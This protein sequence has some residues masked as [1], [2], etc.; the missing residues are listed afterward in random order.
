MLKKLM[1]SINECNIDKSLI[2]NIDII[3]VDNDAARSARK[4]VEELT[5]NFGDF[6][7]LDYHNYPVK[8]LSN[9]RNELL[10]RA[11]EKKPDFVVFIDDDEYATSDWLNELVK[12]IV[13]NRGDMARGPVPPVFEGKVDESI[14]YW[15]KR[16]NYE[17]NTR[18]SSVAAGNLIINMNSLLKFNVW[19]D[20][21]FNST[22]SEDSYFGEQMIKK[23][24]NIFWA[25]Q[26]IAY[27]TIPHDRANLKWILKR[28]FRVASTFAYRLKLAGKQ[29]SLIKKLIVSIGYLI[30]GAIM[31]IIIPFPVKQRFWGIVKLYEGVGGLSGLLSIISK[32]YK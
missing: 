15:F 25:S 12:T 9:V 29:F 26:A 20:N 30:S 1:L 28:R 14:S 21:R 6:W 22:G 10:T 32:E 5:D 4:V 7:T 11:I 19:F 24:A 17:N 18:I 16:S 23:G 31:I 3:V 13:I 2:K 27:E 8:G